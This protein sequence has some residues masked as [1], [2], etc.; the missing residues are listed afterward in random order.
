MELSRQHTCP[1]LALQMGREEFG[2][3]SQQGGMAHNSTERG[4]PA[5]WL[6]DPQDGN[7]GGPGFPTSMH[8]RPG[9]GWVSGNSSITIA[10]TVLA[11]KEH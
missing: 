4:D 10:F 1:M 5:G 2:G 11:K 9:H 8:G 7:T 3:C 6:G